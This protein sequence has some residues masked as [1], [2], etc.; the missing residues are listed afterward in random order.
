MFAFGWID[1]LSPTYEWDS[2]QVRRLARRLGYPV[3]W[4]DPCSVLG[5]A[6]QVAA[7]GADVVLLPSSAH[8]DAVSLNRVLAVADVEC[9]APRVSFARWSRFGGVRR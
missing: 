4:G 7:S 9:A 6:E 8:I 3:R 5:V 1:P 2:G